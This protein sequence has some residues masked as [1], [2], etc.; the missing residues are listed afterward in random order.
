[1]DTPI[2]QKA[3]A[4]YEYLD[5]CA[6]RTK[7]EAGRRQRTG[8]LGGESEGVVEAEPEVAHDGA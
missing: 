6:K 8:V 3:F 7:L 4:K 5:I 2:S 1:M